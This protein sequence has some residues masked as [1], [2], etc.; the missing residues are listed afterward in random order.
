MKIN[1]SRERWVII[2]R[3]EKIFCGLARNYGFK[4]F[5]PLNKVGDM[6]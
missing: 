1:I 4:P 5:K 3:N 6:Q 2:L